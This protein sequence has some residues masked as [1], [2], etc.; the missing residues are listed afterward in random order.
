MLVWKL[1]PSRCEKKQASVAKRLSVKWNLDFS[2]CDSQEPQKRL[3]IRIAF[4]WVERNYF[5]ECLKS[6]KLFFVF[7]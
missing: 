4:Y 2:Y 7:S 3:Y 6:N 5:L 1:W